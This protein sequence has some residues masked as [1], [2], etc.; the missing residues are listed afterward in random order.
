MVASGAVAWAPRHRFDDKDTRDEP[1]WCF[2]RFGKSINLLPDGRI[3]EIAG[4]HED[5]YDPDFCIYNDVIVHR[6]DG[7]FDIYGYPP[8]LFPPTD[9]HTATLAGGHLFLIGNLGYREQRRCGETQ[10]LRL[11]TVSLAIERVATTGEFPGWIS[12]HKAVL[13][14]G[15]SIRIAGG[16]IWEM[17]DGKEAYRDNTESWSLDLQSL[18]WRR[19]RGAD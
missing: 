17:R 12:R 16:K 1:V 10:V 15:G 3:I 11:D 9:F 6:P 5:H 4:E 8:D 18:A 14:A 13:D 2:H 19:I 7:S